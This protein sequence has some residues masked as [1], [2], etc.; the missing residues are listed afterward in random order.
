VSETRLSRKALLAI[1]LLAALLRVSWEVALRVDPGPVGVLA[2]NLLGDE[3]AYDNFA[4]QVAAGTLH[5]ERAFYQ[6]PLYAWTLGQLYKL[7]PPAPLPEQ[8]S[9]VPHAPVHDAVVITQHAMGVAMAVLVA[10]LG[11]RCLGRRAGLLAGLF[12][13]CS[14]PAIFVESMLLKEGCALLLWVVSLHLWL[15]QLEDRPPVRRRAVL[16]GLLLG[17]GILLRGNTYL[18]LGAV[19]LTLV[20]RGGGRRRLPQAALVLVA[21]LAALSPATIHNLRCGDL[22]LSTYQAGSNA[23]IGMPDDPTVWRGVVYEPI[24]AGHG[25]AIFEEQ[26]AI[27]VAEAAEGRRLSGREISAW[28][29][30][31]VWQVVERRPG[32]AAERV[33]RKLAFTFH[34]DEVPDVEDWLFVRKAVPWLATPLSDLT[35]LGPLGLCGLLLLSWRRP[36]LIVVRGSV[37]VVALSLTLFYVFGRYR[38]SACPGLWILSA[39]ALVEGW[40]LLTTPGRRGAGL[41]GAAFA[42]AL[43]AAAQ[44]PLRPDVGGLQVS[45]GNLASLELELTARAKDAPT[46]QAHRDRAVAAA[47]EALRLAPGYPEARSLLINA[48]DYDSALVAPRREEAT[49]QAWRLLLVME[50]E[51][52]G[53][54]AFDL[55]ERPLPVVRDAA[56]TLLARPSLPE[57][58]LYV[59]AAEALACRRIAAELKAPETLDLALALV[60]RAIQLQPDEAKNWLMLGVVAERQQHEVQAVEAFEHTLRLDPHNGPAL[61]HLERL[62]SRAGPAR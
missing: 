42:L 9:I 2:H 18:L 60:Q 28:W 3:R 61:E 8:G 49:D 45:W 17:L 51:R 33:L 16:L 35:V 4:R 52:T 11:A 50:G 56:L 43:V 31:H 41:A 40:R 34:P 46:A 1:A 59:A 6:E 55:L 48:L 23:A 32:V 22:V 7:W 57:R 21:A 12:A 38:L 26:D 27:E 14:G 58:E 36:G 10:T 47:R 25:D 5:R 37:L 53:R 20:L 24:H 15:D 54:P 44:V 29:W 30:R 19:L 62:R 39:G 13:A